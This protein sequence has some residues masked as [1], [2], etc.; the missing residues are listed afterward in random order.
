[1][2]RGPLKTWVMPRFR[3]YRSSP[4]RLNSVS[5]DLSM[6]RLRSRTHDVAALRILP[7]SF[8]VSLK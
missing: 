8:V 5:W 3:T 1:M 7:L 4:S 2:S 6:L